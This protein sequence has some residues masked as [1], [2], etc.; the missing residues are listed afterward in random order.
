MA[1]TAWASA[2]WWFSFLAGELGLLEKKTET[3]RE[4]QVRWLRP[5]LLFGGLWFSP[6]WPLTNRVGLPLCISVFLLGKMKRYYL[7]SISQCFLAVEKLFAM[8]SYR[9]PQHRQEKQR[10]L[11]VAVGGKAGAPP[12][13]SPIE[14]SVPWRCSTKLL[15]SAEDNVKMFQVIYKGLKILKVQKFEISWPSTAYKYRDTSKGYFALKWHQ[16]FCSLLL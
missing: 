13:Q 2:L 3:R 11:P 1:K 8:K 10:R 7:T 9:K 14:F 12:T 16:N 4:L 5:G 6:S 15:V